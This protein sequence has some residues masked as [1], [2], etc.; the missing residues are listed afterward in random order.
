M[1]LYKFDS[2]YSFVNQYKH[3][4]VVIDIDWK[5]HHII[6]SASS[7]GVLTL[8]DTRS[9]DSIILSN[10]NATN[11]PFMEWD[12]EGLFL[13]ILDQT[14]AVKIYK[15]STDPL[16]GNVIQLRGHSN[17]IINAVW[18]SGTNDKC[19]KR[20]YT[21]GLDKQLFIWDVIGENAITSVLLDQVPTAIGINSTDTFL[22]I[23]TYGNVIK[24]YA[25]PNLS[26]SC[27]FYD[28]NV[29]THISW[30]PDSQYISYNVYN[31]QRSV[32]IPINTLSCYQ[33]DYH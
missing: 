14:N 11:F 9:N 24:V 8:F 6:S 30:S 3:P 12:P 13:G 2:T 31:L 18:H 33:S 7:D 20:L 4:T 17:N 16:K 10:I 29:A 5:D 21:I 1:T 23:A 28:Q 27:S 32:I 22:A 15:P 19:I 26:L 25:L